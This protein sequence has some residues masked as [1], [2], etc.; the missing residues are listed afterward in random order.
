MPAHTC[1]STRINTT[2]IAYRLTRNLMLDAGL[3]TSNNNL[4]RCLRDSRADHRPYRHA[5]FNP[6]H[7]TRIDAQPNIS[8]DKASTKSPAGV[9]SSRCCDL[10]KSSPMVAQP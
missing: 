5:R 2:A 8:R 4:R 1:E 6:K 7:L 10:L 3:I 9:A